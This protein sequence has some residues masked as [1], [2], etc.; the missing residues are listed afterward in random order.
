[1]KVGNRRPGA[2]SC[3]VPPELFYTVLQ[4]GKHVH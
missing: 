2:Y 4:V 3:K 1:M